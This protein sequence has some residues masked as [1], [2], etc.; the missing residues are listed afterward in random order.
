MPRER[1]GGGREGGTE[2]GGQREGQRKRDIDSER[3]RK[4]QTDR[5]EAQLHAKEG[6]GGGVV[7]E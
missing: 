5:E 2:N 6:G 1:G 3:K 4:R 7:R